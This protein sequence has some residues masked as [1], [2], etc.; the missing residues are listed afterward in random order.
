MTTGK[1][2]LISLVQDEIDKGATTIEEINKAYSRR[3]SR[4]RS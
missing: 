2:T 4:G 1:K 3:P